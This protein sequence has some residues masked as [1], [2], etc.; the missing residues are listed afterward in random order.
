MPMDALDSGGAPALVPGGTSA[1]P[2][3][4]KKQG[5]KRQKGRAPPEACSPE[6][7]LRHDVEALLGAPAVR[8]AEE[9]GTEWDAPFGMREEVEVEVKAMASNGAFLPFSAVV[10]WG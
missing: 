3:K 6:D 2:P 1:P 9:E 7:V 10:W 4:L 8:A 5:K